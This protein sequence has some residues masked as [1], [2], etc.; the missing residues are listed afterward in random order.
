LKIAVISSGHIPSIWAHSINV[1]KHAGAFQRLGHQVEIL[2]VE[3]LL[4]SRLRQQLESIYAWYGIEEVPIRWFRDRSI[5]FFLET[6]L[7]LRLFPVLEFMGMHNP[8]PRNDPERMISQY[9]AQTNIEIAYCRTF[10]AAKYNLEAGIPTIIETHT[11]HPD[12]NSK[13]L[14]LRPLLRSPA[15][16]KLV[17]IH[18]AI[19]EKWVSMGLPESK[20]MVAEDAVDLAQFDQASSSTEWLHDRLRLRAN[21]RVI[22]YAGS[23][24]PGK[25]IRRLLEAAESMNN[26]K[27]ISFVIVGGAGHEVSH[28]KSLKDDMGLNNVHFTGFVPNQDIPRFLK[29]ADVLFMPH[30]LAERGAVMDINTTSPIKLFE[31]MASARPIVTTRLP[32]IEKIV[33]DGREAILVRPGE[34]YGPALKRALENTGLAEGIARRAYEKAGLFTYE[35]RTEAMLT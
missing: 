19:A 23:L 7:G 21:Q 12:T 2:T 28:W 26:I 11:P 25:G 1:M 13:I 14:G 33:A 24:K 17:T 5:S 35:K 6:S 9:C 34:D 31:Y 3:R 27:D 4:E 32:T 30:D 8:Y 15:L 18:G 10:N 29:S 16:R 20:V 22:M